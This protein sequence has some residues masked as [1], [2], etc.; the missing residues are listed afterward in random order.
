MT[1]NTQT[2][3][4]LLW[5]GLN[6]IYNKTV[7]DWKEEY[8]QVFDIYKSTKAWEEDLGVTGLGLLARRGEGS[9][10]Q[11]DTMHQGFLTRYTH[12]E[13][14]G[15]FKITKIA[16][17]DDQYGV[18]GER[19]AKR[20]AK[21]EKQTR[22]TVAWLIL[23]RAFD[24]NYVGGDAKELL[25]TDHPNAG[26][27]GGT[28]ANELATAA[29]ISEASLEQACIDIGKFV[30][31]RGLKE[32]VKP[33]KI[34]VPIDLDFEVNK[35]MK[36]EYEVGTANNTVNIV[37]SRFP[38]GVMVSHW[39]TDTDA[40]FI[41]TDADNGLKFFERRAPSFESDNDWDTDNVKYKVSTR[42]SCGWTY[43]KALFGSPGA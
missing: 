36:T 21:S 20:L 18:V 33:V 15:G 43:P 14:A 19:G 8:S 42:Y 22:E 32:A 2:M 7:K 34:I 12:A 4:K 10:I 3:S 24:S 28:Y 41:K 17:E 35:I 1:I 9:S 30:D 5:P 40:W 13:F 6:T 38:G 23:N 39:L 31:D 26:G 29:D 11:Y 27:A 25:A 16:M 37:R